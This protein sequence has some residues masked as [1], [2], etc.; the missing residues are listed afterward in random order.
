MANKVGPKE[1]ALKA[2]REAISKT[3]GKISNKK[4][5]AVPAPR[6]G[7]VQSS[8]LAETGSW[9]AK[10][11][12]D[13]Q[14][15]KDA[16]AAVDLPVDGSI[17]DFL[18]R[19][20]SAEQAD[21]RRASMKKPSPS[22][23]VT[24]AAAKLVEIVDANLA[25]AAS[26][27]VGK[28]HERCGDPKCWCVD[29]EADKRWRNWTPSKDGRTRSRPRK[30]TFARA[31]RAERKAA[32]KAEKKV[33]MPTKENEMRTKTQKKT[34]KAKSRVA[35]K[36]KTTKAVARGERS[37][38]TVGEYIAKHKPTMDQLSK[39]FG[40]NAHPLR[41]KMTVARSQGFKIDYDTKDKRYSAVAPKAKKA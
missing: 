41:A 27:S 5:R 36:A 38:A 14:A 16:N 24:L 28:D 18:K 39:H 19:E 1:A 8:T 22:A 9:N 3:V 31:I 23:G 15:I 7:V 29:D 32:A 4:G 35:V 2:Q 11:N 37:P 34:A 30:A 13:A 20:E 25:E 33:V 26:P 10:T 21:A 17:P 6:V 40:M 12:L